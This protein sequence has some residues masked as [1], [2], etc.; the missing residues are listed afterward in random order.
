M[1]SK[2][3]PLVSVLMTVYNREKYIAEAIESVIASSYQNWELIIVDDRS[4]D[5]SVEIARSYEAK[6]DRVKVYVN[7]KNLGDYP[8]RNKATSYAKGKYIKY[9]D[10]DDLI[11]W[12]GLQVMVEAMEKYP[13]ACMGLASANFS[14]K[15]KYP[16]MLTPEESYKYHFFTR[17]FLYTGPTGAI[18][19]TE[20]FRNSG[21]FQ[22][23]YAVA[24]DFGFNIKAALSAPIVVFQSDLFWW[25]QH[26]NQEIK[27]HEDK[28]LLLNH[29]IHRELVFENT[30]IPATDR[31]HIKRNY[32]T[33]YA[34][35]AIHAI[36]HLKPLHASYI[37]KVSK[38]N[39]VDFF[40]ALLPNKLRN[41]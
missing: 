15:Q 14:T 12:Y 24:A 29:Q 22:V 19:K 10:S 3:F 16:V 13:E 25:R 37:Y 36:I 26:E 41:I 7:E 4:T 8:N 2:P 23:E 35:K 33:L 32:Q 28:Y 38:L 30:N 17:G 40:I 39:L 6:D 34:R 1:I 5:S 21:G 11:Y 27:K 18:Y 9:L 31:K 20:Y